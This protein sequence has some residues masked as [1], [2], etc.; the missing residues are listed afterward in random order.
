MSLPAKRRKTGQEVAGPS[1]DLP[2]PPVVLDSA[3]PAAEALGV[4]VE[5][6]NLITKITG[7]WGDIQQ[8]R[9]TTQGASL[10]PF[11]QRSFSK[12]M[13]ENRVYK[14]TC[15]IFAINLIDIITPDVP[16]CSRQVEE[17]KR[18]YFP[19]NGQPPDIDNLPEFCVEVTKKDMVLE[20]AR[21]CLRQ[22]SPIETTL[23]MLR[24]CCRD[25]DQGT[26]QESW[27]NCLLG[28]PMTFKFFESTEAAFMH[29]VAIRQQAMQS[30]IS[31][32]R[33]PLQWAIEIIAFRQLLATQ[34]KDKVPSAAAVAS[35]FKG[36]V[37]ATTAEPPTETFIK[38]VIVVHSRMLAV[39]TI[40]AALA[41]ADEMF[42][43]EHTP[44]RRVNSLHIICQKAQTPDRI[45]FA[46]TMITQLV[47]TKV[48]TLADVGARK[49]KGMDGDVST[50]EYL[51]YV[52]D[53]KDRLLNDQIYQFGWTVTDID[54]CKNAFSSVDAREAHHIIVM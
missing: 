35:K 51:N 10:P 25:L 43:A 42:D 15:S 4:V 54:T 8:A 20:K 41:K 7:C 19:G 31:L 39:P 22:V 3:A 38:N 45:L 12:M 34:N 46:V 9:T 6:G 36:V 33:T 27:Y 17:L 32:Q 16:V 50:I 40:K 21:G 26:D 28:V 49:L 24:A 48:L 11:D 44:F 53:I 47:K 37:F 29:S 14:C 1:P 5:L 13:S 30:G 2:A 18:M 52:K 23:A